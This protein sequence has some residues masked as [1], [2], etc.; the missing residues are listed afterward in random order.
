MALLNPW[1]LIAGDMRAK[2]QWVYADDSRRSRLKALVTDGSFAMICYRLMQSSQQAGLAPLAML[3][4]KL[5][6]ICGRCIIGRGADFGPEFVLIHSLGVVINSSVRGGRG[7][8]LEH[9]VTIGAESQEAP[10]LG[11]DVFV[12][13][14]AKILGKVEVG[15]RTR[16]GANAVVIRDVPDGATAVGVPARIVDRDDAVSARE[17]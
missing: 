6:V 8:K 17:E 5:N 3:F 4:N 13:A 11:N 10:V 12:G 9:Q 15:S 16:I 14:G 2:A 1:K 7:V